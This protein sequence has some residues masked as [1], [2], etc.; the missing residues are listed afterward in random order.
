MLTVSETANL[1][2]RPKQVSFLNEDRFHLNAVFIKNL[3]F[4]LPSFSGTER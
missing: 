1:E 4:K 2:L 3:S